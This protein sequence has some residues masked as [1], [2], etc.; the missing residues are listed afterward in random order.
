MLAGESSEKVYPRPCGGA[1]HPLWAFQPRSEGVYPRPCGGAARRPW[2]RRTAIGLSPPVRGSQVLGLQAVHCARSIP[3]RA[4]EPK[5]DHGFLGWRRVYPRPCGGAPGSLDKLA[6]GPGLSPPVRGSQLHEKLDKL[7]ERSIPARAGEP[8]RSP[9]VG[10]DHRGSIPARAGEPP[11]AFRELVG[12]GVY[13]RPCGGAEGSR[14]RARPSH[15]L[16]PPVRGSLG[17]VSTN[18]HRFGS[19]PARAGE[20]K[21]A[22]P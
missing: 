5:L 17:R 14:C 19:I 3:A 20:P 16:S 8:S 10:A 22:S 21:P 6:H 4:G 9:A 2:K 1:L 15:G 18:D 12:E 11:D 7:K 13:P